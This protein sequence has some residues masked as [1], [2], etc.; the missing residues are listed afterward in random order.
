MVSLNSH[1]LMANEL[2][3][4]GKENKQKKEKDNEKEK[5]K[6]KEWHK[7][8]SPI[9]VTGDQTSTSLNLLWFQML[10]SNP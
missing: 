7:T 5:E 8:E 3:K 4:Q 2:K 10:A 1:S 6:S 9:S